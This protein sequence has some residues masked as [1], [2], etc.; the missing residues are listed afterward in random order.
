VFNALIWSSW[1][2]WETEYGGV[3]FGSFALSF[4]MESSNIDGLLPQ[5]TS[6]PMTSSLL[7]DSTLAIDQRDYLYQNSEESIYFNSPSRSLVHVILPP[8]FGILSAPPAVY[9]IPTPDDLI[10]TALSLL[11]LALSQVLTLL[12]RWRDIAL[13]RYGSTYAV[14][15][16]TFLP[17]PRGSEHN[18]A[19]YPLSRQDL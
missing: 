18:S 4:I 11:C 6:C 13:Y 17:S 15:A 5:P 3:S 2:W 12:N 9:F 16:R 7:L 19:A 1:S 8:G 14:R 10:T